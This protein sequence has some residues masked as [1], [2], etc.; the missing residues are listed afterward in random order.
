MAGGE[1]RRS[2]RI[3]NVDDRAAQAGMIM[4]ALRQGMSALQL[5]VLQVRCLPPDVDCHCGNPCCRGERPNWEWEEAALVV[6]RYAQTAW[7]TDLNPVLARAMVRRAYEK[8]P[9]KVGKLSKRFGVKQEVLETYDRSLRK[10][11]R[12]T[13]EAAGLEADAWVLAG[14]AMRRLGVVGEDA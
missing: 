4:T 2:N 14:D 6:S 11:L 13:R 5:A 9:G 7:G 12:G 10:L 1:G 8:R 3:G